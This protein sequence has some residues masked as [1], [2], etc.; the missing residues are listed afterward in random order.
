MQKEK[1]MK[2]VP[3]PT[4]KRLPVY[5]HYLI[6]AREEGA[7][8]ISAPA[9]AKELNLDPTQ[10]VKDLAYTGIKGRPKIGYNIYELIHFV[11]EYL[12][13]NKVNKAFLV[14]AGNLGSA[15]MAYQAGQT[16]GLKILAAFDISESKIGTKTG[17]VNVLHMKNFSE[18]VKRLDV[19]IGILTT[20]GDVAQKVADEMISAGIKAIWN[21]TP[22]YLKL[23]ENVVVQNTSMYSNV[24]VLL[25]R[26][27]HSEKII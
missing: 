8:N 18:M 7:M 23:P 25:K 22:A 3:E 5:L 2:Q 11:E 16:L 24:A 4:I 15:L 12:G 6:K 19:T 13:F 20:P 14:G 9:I 10:V 17:Q 26:L 27:E 21:L 1:E